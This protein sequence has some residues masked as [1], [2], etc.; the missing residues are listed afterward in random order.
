VVLAALTAQRISATTERNMA[1]GAN[2]QYAAPD[3]IN[4]KFYTE[5]LT[6]NPDNVQPRTSASLLLVGGGED[7]DDAMEWF[8]KRSGYGDI[9]ILRESG[10]DGYNDW[11]M[12]KGVDSV[13]SIV[14]MSRDASSDPKL[15]D[16]I[17]NAEGIFFAGGDQSN[18][19]KFF[20]D[21]PLS[22]AVNQ[23]AA[24]GV[25]VGGTSAGL[26]IMGQYIY[27]ALGESLR[28]SD[29]LADPYHQDLTLDR[30]FLLLPR[31]DALITDSHFEQR[32]R[33][34]RLTAFMARLLQNGWT[35]KIR[36]LGINEHTAIGID[37]Y[38]TG[39][40]FADAG[41]Q[42]FVL[43]ANQMPT[44][45]R[46]H[47]PLSFHQISVE[48]LSPGSTIDFNTWL[49]TGSSSSTIDVERG[50]LSSSDGHIYDYMRQF[51]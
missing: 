17:K 14:V 47:Q 36:G 19:V 2:I 37:E 27:A 50:L 51:V 49:I 38:G 42:A 13:D 48:R 12:T 35:T 39:T 4:H 23:A 33:M 45:C 1:G 34:G 24:R 10:R 16:K 26:A 32:N 3:P 20:K 43:T 15:L 7:R 28:S 41:H 46:N 29:A 31:L 21:T 9:L 11:L 8:V 18:Y 30:D 40:L 44:V 5:Y 22:L 6:G 25:P